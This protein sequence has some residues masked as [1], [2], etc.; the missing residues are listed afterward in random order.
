MQSVSVDELLLET[1][2]RAD[3][4]NAIARFPDAEVVSYLNRSF[5]RLYTVLDQLDSTYF[6]HQYTITTASGA[7]AYALPA[8]FWRLKKVTL[9]LT[10]NVKVTISKY[11][12]SEADWFDTTGV[13]GNGYPLM[14]RLVGNTIEFSP[15]PVGAYTV[16]ID[17]VQV[18]P[19]LVLGG[20]VDAI[21]GFD[22][23]VI[24]DSAIKIKRKNRVDA[25]DLMADLANIEVWLIS[26]AKDRDTGT[27]ECIADVQGIGLYG[28]YNPYTF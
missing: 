17:Y 26:V 20:S 16:V 21:A 27:P 1:R 18:P 4:E 8:D 2:R 23:W 5:L 12:P 3:I 6:R 15:V 25:S 19:T 28:S 14:Y 11:Q 9:N 22:E 7:K 24:L 10:G 13:W